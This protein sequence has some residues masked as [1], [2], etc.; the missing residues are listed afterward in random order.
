MHA[1]RKTDGKTFPCGS[2]DVCRIA[3]GNTNTYLSEPRLIEDF[4]KLVE[5]KYNW[6]CAVFERGEVDPDAVF[7]IA[8]FV[9]FVMCC[10]PTGMR[11]GSAPHEARLPIE[12]A[13]MER[14]G[15][16]EPPPPELGGKTLTEL[17]ADGD[18]VF[19]VDSRF[20]QAIGISNIVRNVT[21]FGNFYWDIL[22][23]EH[24]DSPFFTSDFP[25]AVEA[26]RDP[27]IVNRVIPLTPNLAVRICP[28]LELSG[29]QLGPTF[30]HF[31]YQVLKP[32]RQ[33]VIAL[34]RTIV[35]SAE[36][37]VFYPLSAP[38]VAG[39]VRKHSVYEVEIETT[40]FPRGTGFLSVSRTVV[41]QRPSSP[42]Q[43]PPKPG[44]V[45]RE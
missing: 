12:A 42:N 1:F 22:L 24:A 45:V 41:R 19:D 11:L 7:V 5:P 23:N 15:L 2:E 31:S 43:Y 33:E 38:W 40:N 27:R 10:S 28:R 37:L 30:E 17:L 4:V 8:G 9:A 18:I 20:P 3:E 14:V 36:K 32:S 29:K 25:V 6:A 26:S 34:N 44:T 39:F 13:L 21:A 35:R 16:I